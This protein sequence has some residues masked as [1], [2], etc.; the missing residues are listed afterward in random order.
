MEIFS[1]SFY[2]A[3]VSTLPIGPINLVLLQLALSR[4]WQEWASCIAGVTAVDILYSLL[5]LHF[6]HSFSYLIDGIKPYSPVILA[7]LFM[8]F[9]I[10]M[11]WPRP[12]G[13]KF[14]SESSPLSFLLVGSL[15]TL[16]EPGLPIF[17][18]SWWS[19]NA[20]ASPELPVAGA[21]VLLG[22]LTVFAAYAGV[23]ILF[24]RPGRTFEKKLTQ[25][26]GYIFVGAAIFLMIRWQGGVYEWLRG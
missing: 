14:S 11:L 1:S 16:V 13:S 21:G 5:S 24:P 2:G 18:L 20:V 7:L 22:D 10:S 3:I 25:A 4:R 15:A 6:F 17:W 23:A 12:K 19:F 9:G 26:V 8:I